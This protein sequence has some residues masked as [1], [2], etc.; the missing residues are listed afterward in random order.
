M[1]YE[2]F[3]NQ[4]PAPRHRR[5]ARAQYADVLQPLPEVA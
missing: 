3:Q 5:R 1:N 2:G 4:S